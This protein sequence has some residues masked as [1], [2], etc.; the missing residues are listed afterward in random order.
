M[1]FVMNIIYLRLVIKRKL[2]QGS[3]QI[4]LIQIILSMHQLNHSLQGEH[5][6]NGGKIRE[7]MIKTFWLQLRMEIYKKLRS[8]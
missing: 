5:G 3:H 4:N 6:L 7:K 2:S 1:I 8:Y